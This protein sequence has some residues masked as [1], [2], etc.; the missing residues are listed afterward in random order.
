M[1]RPKFE[2]ITEEAP[3]RAILVGIDR[4]NA[5]W[6]LR[7]SMAELERLANTAG[8]EVVHTM[9]QRLDAPNPRTFIGA[10]KAEELAGGVHDLHADVVI[11]DDELSPSQQSNLE[12]IVGK[13]VKVIDRTALIL[14]IFAL[15]A[16]SR[17]GRLQVKLAQNQY[18]YP[19][20]RGMWSHLAAHRMGGGVGSRFGEGESQ[21]EVDRRLV[22]KRIGRI[23]REL[24]NLESSRNTQRK[25]RASSGVFRVALAGYTNAGKSSLM[26]ALT[27]SDVLAYD[28]LFATLDSTTRALELPGSSKVT[29][30]DTVGFIQK[31]PHN[32]VEAFHST[33]DEIREADLVLLVVD[34][35]SPQRAAQLKAVQDVLGQI[36]ASGIPRIVVFNKIDLVEH[37]C[38]AELDHL[39]VL[40]PDAAFISAKTGSGIED[41][42]VRLES[43]VASRYTPMS[44]RIPYD[45]GR[46]VTIAH[47]QARVAHGSYE[48]DGIYLQVCLPA[49]L[50]KQFRQFEM[51]TEGLVAPEQTGDDA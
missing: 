40:H 47:E 13:P 30:T 24:A 2:V 36:G 41:L 10:G 44:V 20:L 17:E 5:D 48:A 18:L 14:D 49:N 22:R 6:P 31:L 8:A 3:E 34:A 43:E 9:S 50:A 42:L 23:R 33:L 26:N 38:I 19:R 35:A 25:H 11:L 28:K 12:R 7:E 46:Y 1:P 21:L 27:D 51:E 37:D 16:T 29:L 39:R 15:H 32:L 45:Q 4:G